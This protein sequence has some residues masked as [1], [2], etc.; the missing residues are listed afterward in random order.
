MQWNIG[1]AVGKS[2]KPMNGWT[3]VG[4]DNWTEARISREMGFLMH[5]IT[6]NVMGCETLQMM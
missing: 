4:V 1:V 2:V 3:I 5:I 6:G